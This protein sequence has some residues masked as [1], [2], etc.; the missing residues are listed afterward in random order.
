VPAAT[1][2]M[3]VAFMVAIVG[4]QVQFSGYEIIYEIT[5]T[6]G[7]CTCKNIDILLI[8]EVD[9][10]M[11][12]SPGNYIRNIILG[13][14]DGI[15]PGL[16]FRWNNFRNVMDFTVFYLDQCEW[17][18]VTEVGAQLAVFHG[19]CDAFVHLQEYKVVSQ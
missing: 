3:L 2:L 12:H 5:G 14:P 15:K 17:F 8:K 6:S 4:L 11:T 18:T 9:G 19:Y 1:L 10:F 7:G 16:V 13:K